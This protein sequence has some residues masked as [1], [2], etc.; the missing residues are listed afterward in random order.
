[1]ENDLGHWQRDG[2][3]LGKGKVIDWASSY[4]A[5]LHLGQE[6]TFSLTPS[7]IQIE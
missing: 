6:P 4:E 3:E 7:S 1:M 5:A 2:I